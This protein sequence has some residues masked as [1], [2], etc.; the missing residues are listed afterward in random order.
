MDAVILDWLNL[1]LRWAHLIA[2]I[3]WI[4][5]S[6]YFMWLD[7]AL[8]RTN[9]S[10]PDLEGYTWLLHSGGF[11]L[12]ERRKL[13]PGQ[14]PSPIHWFKWEAGMTFLTGFPLLVLVYYMTGGLYLVD[15]AVSSITPGWAAVVGVGLLIVSWAV[16]D[17]I[18]TS[19]LARGSG[20]PAV[21]VSWIL[22]F[23]VVY[24]LTRVLSGRA[25]FIHVGAMLGTIMV[26]NVWM[27][28]I[29]AQKDLIASAEAGRT[30]D[31]TLSTRAKQRST[32]NSYVTFPVIFMMLSH[33]YPALYAHPLNWLMLVL[34]IVAGA[35]VRQVM[36]ARDKGKPTDWW[37]VPAAAALGVAVFLTSPAWLGGGAGGGDRVAFAAVKGV[38]ERRCVSCHSRTPTDDV[39]KVAPNNVTFDAPESIR[40]HAETIRTRVVLL[41]NMPLANKTGITELERA[42]LARWIAQGAALDGAPARP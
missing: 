6:L 27:R 17:Q 23:A 20:R 7:A 26:A 16:Y 22:L 14:L 29:P 5:T 41:K 31:D 15:P 12:V 42:L 28:I 32:H 13:P 30:V 21:V 38:I 4:G 34:L 8:I 40:A 25:A 11:Y 36:L 1:G 37:L 39:F 9:L 2:G 19:P 18:W 33:H 10:R 35:A 3:G 24:G